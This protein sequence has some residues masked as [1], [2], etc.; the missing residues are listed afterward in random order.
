[1]DIKELVKRL[2]PLE[3]KI[4]PFLKDCDTLPE[5]VKNSELQEAQVMKGLQF[6]EEKEAL[7]I[8]VKESKKIVLAD[9]AVKYKELPERRVINTLSDG[10]RTLREVKEKTGLS[11]T[12]V[13][14]CV[15]LLRR[16]NA[17]EV[18][19]DKEL[20]IKLTNAGKTLVDKR[21]PEE[22]LFSRLIKEKMA[23]D[24]LDEGER[25]GF[26]ELRKR[27]LVD[28][29]SEKEISITL[30]SLGERLTKEKVDVDVI[31][32]LTPEMMKSG[33][34][35]KKSFRAY[36]VKAR[37]PEIYGGK[38]HPLQDTMNQ[39]R[40]IFLEMGFKEME[41]PLVETA[42]WCMDA[43]W[44]PQ[45]HP[46]R[47]V[48]DTFYLPYMGTIPESLTKKVREVHE[49]GGDS[50]SR[51]YGYK[52][53]EKIA[54]QLLLRTHTTSTTFRYFGEKKIKPP[55]KYFYIG[56]IFRNEAIDATHLPE[57]H[58]SEGFIMDK[59]LTLKDLMGYIREFYQRMGVDKIK[60]KPTYNPYTEPSMECIGYN[61][62]LGKWVELI[63][64]G[65]F[66]PEAL[67]PYGIN[68]PVIA[69]GLGVERLAMMLHQ[70]KD[71]RNMLG[72]AGDLS[73]FR[74]SKVIK[75]W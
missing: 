60:F 3:R 37:V 56:R 59:G 23:V 41:G 50:G 48:Q 49:R 54:R 8:K 27:G 2:H 74:K 7:K 72:A 40:G 21:T 34:W 75:K 12:E 4:L 52:W 68:V 43:M 35:E 16:K 39:I 24:A 20:T 63:N 32:V 9:K 73:W 1:M 25:L 13:N 26:E 14:A 17:I 31:E 5:L 30:T 42:F 45:N 70:Q 61:K 57:F 11:D 53:D 51:G 71:I 22:E 44:I 64:S 29:F 19:R 46:A 69:W 36:E 55:A 33:A 62:Q 10:G 65:V 18:A 28:V 47:D 15:G 58:Q 38:I 6:L 66:R 67:E